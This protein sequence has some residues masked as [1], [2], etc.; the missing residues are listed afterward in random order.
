M[1]HVSRGAGAPSADPRQKRGAQETSG[2][3]AA[4]LLDTFLWRSKEK[5]LALG[6]ENP[7]Q[8]TVALSDSLTN[9]EASQTF[10]PEIKKRR[11]F[12][13]RNISLNFRHKKAGI[14]RLFCTSLYR[15]FN[16]IISNT[17]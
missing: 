6:C 5:Y 12:K 7:I 8:I 10:M 15:L 11:I 17:E 9:S 13:N 4:F 16:Q 3:R 2:N 1:P 14:D